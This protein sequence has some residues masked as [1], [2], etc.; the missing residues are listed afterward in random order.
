MDGGPRRDPGARG[1]A[2]CGAL[3]LFVLLVGGL[4]LALALASAGYIPWLSGIVGGALAVA[5][6]VMLLA[7]T[8]SGPGAG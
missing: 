5:V 6:F 3:A 4:I 8:G 2:G 1:F 7:S